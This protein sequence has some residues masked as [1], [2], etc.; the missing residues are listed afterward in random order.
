[1]TDL[2]K[3]AALLDRVAS[4]WADGDLERA[5]RAARIVWCESPMAYRDMGTP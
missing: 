1:M 2:A 4:A 3:L 5:A